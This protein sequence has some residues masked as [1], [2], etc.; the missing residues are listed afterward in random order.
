MDWIKNERKIVLFSPYLSSLRDMCSSKRPRVRICS[1][2]TVLR[3]FG[4]ALK[5]RDDVSAWSALGFY[6]LFKDSKIFFTIEATTVRGASRTAIFLPNARNGSRRVS[7]TTVIKVIAR[8]KGD[9]LVARNR[10]RN[11]ER[12]RGLTVIS[13]ILFLPFFYSRASSRFASLRMRDLAKYP[14]S[15]ATSAMSTIR[16]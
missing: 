6:A 3:L 9:R 16:S 12:E 1:P 5:R 14:S 8:V 2:V 13:T 7:E 10:A 4:P 15:S 11:G